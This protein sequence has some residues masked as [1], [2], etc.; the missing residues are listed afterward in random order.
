M[1][2]LIA[3]SLCIACLAAP[4]RAGNPV[5]VVEKPA[6]EVNEASPSGKGWLSW[7]VVPL[8]LCVVMCGPD[9]D[10]AGDQ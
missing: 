5:V 3:P 1:K 9:G 2:P 8:F 10:D 7:L 4:V 6:P